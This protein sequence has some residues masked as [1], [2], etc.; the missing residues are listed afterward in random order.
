MYTVHL[1]YE[2]SKWFAGIRDVQTVRR[3]LARLRKAELGNL[4]DV[5]HVGEGDKSTQQADIVRAIGLAHS[6]DSEDCHEQK[7]N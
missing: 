2:F 1:T 6:L 5:R 7:E 3:L 4:G